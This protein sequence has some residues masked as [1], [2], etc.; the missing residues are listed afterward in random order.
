MYMWL[1]TVVYFVSVDFVTLFC[2]IVGSVVLLGLL[3]LVL[4]LRGF[5]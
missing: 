5:V 2:L 3:V 4:L 1:F